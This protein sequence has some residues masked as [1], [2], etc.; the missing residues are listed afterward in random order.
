MY[1]VIGKPSNLH[2]QNK[3]LVNKAILKWNWI[4]WDIK[5]FL[6]LI[7]YEYARAVV[8]CFR[9]L[10]LFL[11]VIIIFAYAVHFL[12]RLCVFFRAELT[13]FHLGTKFRVSLV[14]SS[15]DYLLGA[16]LTNFHLDTPQTNS[17]AKFWVSRLTG[18][19]NSPLK[20]VRDGNYPSSIWTHP[21]QTNI[22]N[23]ES[24]SIAP[25]LGPFLLPFPSYGLKYIIKLPYSLTLL[26]A[27][28]FYYNNSR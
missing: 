23:L 20:E 14:T 9:I 8:L 6:Y 17:N 2:L 10:K 15:G 12:M 16:L 1:W 22:S 11:F 7:K 5:F 27:V 4:E 18:C 25:P 26:E 21:R 13:Y 19:K 28:L 24:L 3:V